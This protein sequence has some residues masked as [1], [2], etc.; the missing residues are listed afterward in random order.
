MSRWRRS[1]CAGSGAC[2]AVA[3]PTTPRAW[4]APLRRGPARR[5]A[6]AGP[7]LSIRGRRRSLNRA[8]TRR[9]GVRAG[10]PGARAVGQ[11]GGRDA[12]RRSE[13][14]PRHPPV[15]RGEAARV[16]YVEAPGGDLAGD[17]GAPLPLPAA[18]TRPVER[19]RQRGRRIGPLRWGRG[20]PRG[21]GP[22]ERGL[23]ASRRD[24]STSRG[25]IY[26]DTEKTAGSP[27]LSSPS[28]NKHDETCWDALAMASWG[29]RT[30]YS[31]RRRRRSR[32]ARR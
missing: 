10:E 21:R 8:A 7:H 14:R 26:L 9:V 1:S 29:G 4:T 12:L 16:C 19:L 2:G 3:S 5:A 20:A 30:P 6:A 28:L 17:R 15:S 18:R 11:A 22:R 27:S 13:R 32:W 24:A 23:R 25:G 31:S